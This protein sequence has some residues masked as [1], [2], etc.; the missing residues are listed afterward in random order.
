MAG[1]MMHRS[2]SVRRSSHSFSSSSSSPSS[3]VVSSGVRGRGRR[4]AL[5]VVA[6]KPSTRTT[7]VVLRK[8]VTNVGVAGDVASVKPGY[9]RNYL[10]PYGYAKLATAEV[11]AEV[12]AK[13]EAEE[14]KRQEVKDHA[15]QLATALGTIGKLVVKR[16]AGSAAESGERQIFGS[17]S[18]GDVVDV[19]KEQTQRD[20]EKT[21]IS[22]PEI[23]H[24]GEYDVS[25]V[26]HPEVT[27]TFKLVVAAAP[28]K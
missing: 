9:F 4:G 24:L 18:A 14:R 1:V 8:D 13:L 7:R 23:K 5:V 21:A 11:L 12:Q 20:V 25:V 15:Q 19:I 6:N 17:V 2:S 10:F 28:A 26:L 22:L 3:P 27:A 16:K